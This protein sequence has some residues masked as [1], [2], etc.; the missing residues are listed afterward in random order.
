MELLVLGALW[1]GRRDITGNTHQREH[2]PGSGQ[3]NNATARGSESLLK[4]QQAGIEGS[5]QVGVRAVK[6]NR[7]KLSDALS[8]DYKP[9]A[10][11]RGR[12]S[13]VPQFLRFLTEALAKWVI[14]QLHR[15]KINATPVD[16]DAVLSGPSSNGLSVQVAGKF[17]YGRIQGRS[18]RRKT[19]S[20]AS[21][22]RYRLEA[23]PVPKAKVA[24]APSLYGQL[25]DSYKNRA[26]TGISTY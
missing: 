17:T 7:C 15:V 3:R 8:H 9:T 16:L 20:T 2:R 25:S 13:S 14:K 21:D 6:R 12:A 1:P 4:S 5:Q 10:Q 22:R 19:V 26:F 23:A 11:A 18:W 24:A